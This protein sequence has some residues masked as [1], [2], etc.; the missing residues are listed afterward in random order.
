MADHLPTFWPERLRSGASRYL[1][2]RG[3]LTERG[4]SLRETSLHAYRNL[5]RSEA[6]ERPE[7]LAA[8]EE[9]FRAIL[10]KLAGETVV[11]AKAKAAGLGKHVEG[12]RKSVDAHRNSVARLDAGHEP[13]IRAIAIAKGK[14]LPSATLDHTFPTGLM[15]EAVDA[16]NRMVRAFDYFDQVIIAAKAREA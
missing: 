9:G 8:F 12:M 1:D 14:G 7:T 16:A 4:A 10:L 3:R 15:A 5:H 2:E 13:L 11:A 6:R